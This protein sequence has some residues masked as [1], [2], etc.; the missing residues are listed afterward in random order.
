MIAAFGIAVGASACS[1][2]G[3]RHGAPATPGTWTVASCQVDVTYIDETNTVEKYVPDIDAT[4]SSTTHATN[5]A[6]MRAWL[7]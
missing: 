1:S 2:S 6:V 5:S 4:S 7:W 3:A